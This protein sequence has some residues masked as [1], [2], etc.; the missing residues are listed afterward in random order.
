[1]DK[2]SNS[3]SHRVETSFEFQVYGLPMYAHVYTGMIVYV[4]LGCRIE[5]SLACLTLPLSILFF[6]TGSL[7]KLI[8]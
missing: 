1:M 7:T 5:K 2:A 4:Y 6:E 8:I 3:V